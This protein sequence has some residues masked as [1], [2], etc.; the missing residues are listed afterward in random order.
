MN[1][2][3]G[4]ELDHVE[5]AGLKKLAE[6]HGIDLFL[7]LGSYGTRH[8]YPGRSDIDIAFLSREKLLADDYLLLVAELSALF[9]Y[10]KID[11]IDLGKVAGLL[12]Y[13]VADKGRLIYQRK[14]GLFERYT[15]YCLRYYYDTAK[16]RLLKKEHFQEQLGALKDEQPLS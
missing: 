9:Q 16:F 12:K 13:E 6:K 3:I 1:P 8:F 5:K 15:L 4:V 7:L 2:G 10:E 14:A 11:L